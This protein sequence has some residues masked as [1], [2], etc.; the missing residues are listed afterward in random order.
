MKCPLFL[1]IALFIA[2]I[3]AIGVD[4]NTDFIRFRDYFWAYNRCDFDALG[5]LLEEM[6]SSDIDKI[7]FI[8]CCG[9]YAYSAE[10][11]AEAKRIFS[12]IPNLLS[13]EPKLSTG[14]LYKKASYNLINGEMLLYQSLLEEG[15]KHYNE[16]KEMSDRF[17]AAYK[18]QYTYQLSLIEYIKYRNI[19][20]SYNIL[21]SIDT[22]YLF[23]VKSV[24][25]YTLRAIMEC[26][27]LKYEN[28]LKNIEIA[29]QYPSD[30]NRTLELR[31]LI[32]KAII[33]NGMGREDE[34]D[35]T[36]KEIRDYM[37]EY[38]YSEIKD[39]Y[40]SMIMGQPLTKQE[41][42]DINNIRKLVME[43]K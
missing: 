6:R 16:I 15:N 19:R 3:S 33:L 41:R 37:T 20:E 35:A 40:A 11:H 43:N 21:Q 22:R 28:A 32:W 31:S 25:Y 29:L 27:S 30:I 2:T 23:S 4:E 8:Y 9:L 18:A 13:S 12:E 38:G 26:N 1:V 14:K 34:L 24:E 39:C 42:D 10:K 36:V 7:E 17:D 5:N